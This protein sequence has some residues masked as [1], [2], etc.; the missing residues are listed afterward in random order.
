MEL[1]KSLSWMCEEGTIAVHGKRKRQVRVIPNVRLPANAVSLTV[2]SCSEEC[3][4]ACLENC[5]CTGYTSD[6]ECTIWLEDLL[7]IQYLSFDDN[8]GRHLRV[9]AVELVYYK[10]T[11]SEGS[12]HLP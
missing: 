2:R 8:L 5:T 1:W 9:A 3:E 12:K 7:N 10:K 6:G 11:D 4:A